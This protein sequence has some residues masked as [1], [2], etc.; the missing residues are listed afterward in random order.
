LLAEGANV[1]GESG[2][3]VFVEY[4]GQ[5]DVAECDGA[6]L[7]LSGL[8]NTSSGRMGQLTT[9]RPRAL[10]PAAAQYAQAIIAMRVMVTM[11][12]GNGG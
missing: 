2:F 4:S 11:Q 1:S 5:H 10:G 12:F 3:A 9:A 8:G 7:L 6:L